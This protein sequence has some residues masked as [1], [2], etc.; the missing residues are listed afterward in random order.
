MAEIEA[1]ESETERRYIVNDA[2][3]EKAGELLINNPRG[4]LYLRDEVVDLL[5]QSD[6]PGNEHYRPFLLEAWNAKGSYTFDWIGRGTLHIPALCLSVCGGIQPGRFRSHIAGALAE[7]DESDGLLQRFQL[8]VWFDRPRRWV[9]VYEH[10]DSTAKNRAFKL[11]EFFDK[12]GELAQLYCDAD[13]GHAL[14]G[15]HFGNGAQELFRSWLDALMHRI[16]SDEV[17]DTPAF[18]AHL[19]NYPSLVPSLALIFH[20]LNLADKNADA[21]TPITFEATALAVSWVEYLELHAK[22]LYA[23]EL[24]APL[25]NAHMLAEKIRTGEV[26]YGQKV[27]DIYRH[28]WLRLVQ[29]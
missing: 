15:L 25:T 29:A 9:Y 28:K 6:R 4:L 10:P 1:L 18:Q 22:K 19:A 16:H 20:R 11:F 8:L 23:S 14:P 7:S 17:R 12:V 21:L 26:I 3:G 27:S 13:D 5:K 24:N 2:T